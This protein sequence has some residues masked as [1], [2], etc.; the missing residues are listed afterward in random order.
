M[1]PNMKT[2]PWWLFEWWISHRMP[3]RIQFAK[4]AKFNFG[5]KFSAFPKATWTCNWLEAR[6]KPQNLFSFFFGSQTAYRP[7]KNIFHKPRWPFFLDRHQF[8][9]LIACTSIFAQCSFVITFH[10]AGFEFRNNFLMNAIKS[11]NILEWNLSCWVKLWIGLQGSE[12]KIEWDSGSR[13]LTFVILLGNVR[14][15]S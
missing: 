2:C 15:V 4:S 3:W 6:T 13:W 10:V 14:V 9:C 1:S 11:C 8:F 12:M 5:R 7:S